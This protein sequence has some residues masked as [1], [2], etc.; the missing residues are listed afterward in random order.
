[1]WKDSAFLMA[2]TDITRVVYRPVIIVSKHLLL[3][4]RRDTFSTVEGDVEPEHI[5]LI[6]ID[7]LM[8]H[9]K[10]LVE[11]T[12]GWPVRIDLPASGM[13]YG[14]SGFAIKLPC[15]LIRAII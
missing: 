12:L 2:D 14:F 3:I 13:G 11:V 6:L 4:L 1:M 7:D 5:R 9:A 8:H 10:P 15:L